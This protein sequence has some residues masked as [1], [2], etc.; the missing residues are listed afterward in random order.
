MGL[1][2]TLLTSSCSGFQSESD[3]S[4]KISIFN[5][6]FDRIDSIYFNQDKII[7]NLSHNESRSSVIIN[8]G[9]NELTIYTESQIVITS[10]IQIRTNQEELSL[11]I[12]RKG[13]ISII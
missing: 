12:G 7:E 10:K 5:D 3:F 2:V 8:K 13:K 9:L 4:V 6:Y 11:L 1:I